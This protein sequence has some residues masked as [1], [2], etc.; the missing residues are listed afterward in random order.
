MTYNDYIK[1][2][3]K[4]ITVTNP[5]GEPL[6]GAHVLFEGTGTTTDK[7]GVAVVTV[8]DVMTFVD[9]SHVSGETKTFPFFDLPEVVVISANKMPPVVITAEKKKNWWIWGGVGIAVIMLIATNENP[10]KITI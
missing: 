8:E 6:Q 4:T 10:K 5:A 3:T 7:N 1:M 2:N 9:I